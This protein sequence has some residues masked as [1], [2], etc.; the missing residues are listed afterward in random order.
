M[1]WSFMLAFITAALL[2]SSCSYL[3]FNQ[4]EP[5]RY[6]VK[7]KVEQAGAGTAYGKELM[8]N[9]PGDKWVYFGTDKS[10][11]EEVTEE[12]M[13][14]NM[15]ETT[16][17]RRSHDLAAFDSYLKINS[18]GAWDHG[19]EEYLHPCPIPR[20]VFPVRVG[21]KWSL[22][23]GDTGLEASAEVVGVDQVGTAMGLFEAV[24]VQYIVSNSNDESFSLAE[25]L[26]FV[27]GVGIVQI[28]RGDETYLLRYF[29]I[30]GFEAERAA[31]RIK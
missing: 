17:R 7:V 27:P 14:I 31:A 30:S 24:R 26:W 28:Q 18:R 20:L 5:T 9:S 22:S 23:N 25:V 2:A 12:V 1:R 6:K 4:P 13:P 21:K 11:L 16:V 8:P 3:E 15:V 10:Y 29:E 19:G